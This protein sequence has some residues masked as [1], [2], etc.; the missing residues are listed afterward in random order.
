[1]IELLAPAGS[2]E[3]LDAAIAEGADSVYL[4]LKAFNARMRSANFAYSQFE[5]AL[6]SLHRMG[7]KVYVTVNTVFEQREADRVYQLLKYLSAVG[8]D[9]IIVQDFGVLMMARD[10][11]GLRLHAS[12]QMNIASARGANALSKY[13]VSRV[14]LARELSLEE[15]RGIRENTNMELEVFV[16]GALCASASGLCLFSSYL[17]GKSA[18]RGLCTQACRRLYRTGEG[19]DRPALQD[20]ALQDAAFRDAVPRRAA[21]G[22]GGARNGAYY[23]SPNDLSLIARV[24]DLVEAGAGIFKIEGRMKSAE[25]VGTVVWAYRKVIDSLGG[26]ED[27]YR[28]ALDHAQGILKNDFGRPK[29]EFFAG[30]EVK[31]K[32]AKTAHAGPGGAA[33][34]GWFNPDQDGG[35]GIGL[36]TIISATGSGSARRALVR[37]G[38]SLTPGDTI[39][40]HRSDDSERRSHKLTLAEASGTDGYF[41]SVPGEFGPGD[42]VYL[43]QTKAMTKRYPRIIPGDLSP[44][45]RSPGRD[46]APQAPEQARAAL[47]RGL[48]RGEDGKFPKL[49]EGFYAALASVEDLYIAQSVRPAAVILPVHSKT[50]RALLQ[51]GDLPFKTHEI[52]L[53]LDPYFPQGED[54]FLQ[55]ALGKLEERG[56]RR[57]ILNNPGHFSFFSKFKD[58]TLL[59]AGPWLYTFNR[60]S[61]AFAAALGARAIISPLENNRQNLE[62]TMD[63]KMRPLVLLTLFAWPPLFRIRGDL[64]TRYGFTH[65]T[66]TRDES[67]SM[68]PGEKNTVVIPDTPFSIVDKTPFLRAAGFR[69]FILDF[70]A[71]TF[72]GSFPLKKK[73]YREVVKAAAQGLSLS[74]VSR[75]N[76]KD[77][78]FTKPEE[79]GASGRRTDS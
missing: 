25:Y 50:L 22:N 12:T 64:S 4:G 13:G 53:A 23:F 40:L 69:R 16:H 24:P 61:A 28:R 15:I 49:P 43:I 46:R 27:A 26:G 3:A 73:L 71:G 63:P 60:W 18:N 72:T 38:L 52:I 21:A 66:G 57:F 56:Y 36:G 65:F 54:A 1:M 17:G 58:R 8:P 79:P 77:G 59:I 31:T 7:R 30:L 29:T 14:V 10:F 32:T 76:W 35:T 70:S 74:G 34:P 78:F 37:P 20:L 11:P 41:I 47:S 44:F 33:A 45:K 55:D 67:F 19:E 2:Q 68:I 51:T 6:R 5:G 48:D 39:R 75:F 42:S 9:G 62:K